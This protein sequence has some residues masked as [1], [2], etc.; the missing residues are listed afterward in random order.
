MLIDMVC[1]LV[2][3]SWYFILLNEQPKGFFKSYRELKQ[4]D[5]LSPTLFVIAA[6]VMSMAL[7]SLMWAKELKIFVLPRGSPKV[8]H[9]TFTD[10]TIILCKDKSQTI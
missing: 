5:P 3:N 9:F 8:N 2:G 4:R 10:D 6:E 7:K 1:R